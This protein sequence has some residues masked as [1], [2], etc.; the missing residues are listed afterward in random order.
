L[1]GTYNNGSA[2][3]A[4]VDT[5]LNAG[6]YYFLVDGVAN[7]FTP[8]YG[9]LGSYSIVASQSPLVTLPLHKFI[10]EG[11]TADYLHKL[12]WIIEADEKVIYL[13]IEVSKDGRHFSSVIEPGTNK[14]S[15]Q[16]NPNATGALQ[17]RI[18]AKFD[19]GRQYYSNVIA[20]NS[21]AA[22]TKPQLFTNVITNNALMISSSAAYSYI[23]ADYNGRMVAKGTIAHGAS[24]VRINDV[25]SGIYFI[26][27]TNGQAQNVE[28]FVKE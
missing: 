19:N 12:G 6:T 8:E 10:L 1:I 9:S 28:R 22:L 2:L 23:I 20:L 4:S 14:R 5:I 3:S 27:F 16:Y 21:N 18:N 7:E 24:T 25:S 13:A 17:Y 26:H 11:S 15:Y